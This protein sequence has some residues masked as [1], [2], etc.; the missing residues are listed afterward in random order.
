MKARTINKLRTLAGAFLFLVLIFVGKCHGQSTQ[1]QIERVCVNQ[2]CR[3]CKG[4]IAI[5]KENL[6]IKIDSSTTHLLIHKE[7][8][9]LN[10]ESY[11]LKDHTGS[12]YRCKET[13]YLEIYSPGC[14]W[15]SELYYLKEE[16]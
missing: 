12:F 13:A 11:K 10:R 16:L 9:Y 5:S 7:F 6:Y 1:Y 15:Y 8:I 2:K 4:Y 14:G 3:P